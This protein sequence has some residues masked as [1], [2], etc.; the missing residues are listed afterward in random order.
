MVT[1]DSPVGCGSPPVTAEGVGIVPANIFVVGAARR[2]M[3]R[4]DEVAIFLNKV[5]SP[6]AAHLRW[7][8][9]RCPCAFFFSLPLVDCL[10]ENCPKY[11]R[12]SPV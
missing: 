9:T 3:A 11:G 5:K 7:P 1:I 6:F 10:C 4:A 12:L 8:E 2:A